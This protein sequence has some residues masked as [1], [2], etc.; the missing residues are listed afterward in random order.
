[1]LVAKDAY[2]TNCQKITYF[3][4][5]DEGYECQNCKGINT[6]KGMQEVD[7]DEETKVDTFFD[8]HLPEDDL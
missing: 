3:I 5:V 7:M 8:L 6:M 4:P 2:C 1:M